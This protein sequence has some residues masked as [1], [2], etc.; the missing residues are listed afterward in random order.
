M[1][2]TRVSPRP[3][4]RSTQV[5]P[6]SAPLLLTLLAASLQKPWYLVAGNRD[7]YSGNVT[8]EVAYSGQSP[9]GRWQME[10]NYQKKYYTALGQPFLHMVYLD[11]WDMTSESKGNFNSP[12][13]DSAKGAAAIQWM[14]QAFTDAPGFLW[15]IV[16]THY[17]I[18]C[19]GSHG[20]KNSDL[21]GSTLEGALYLSGVDAYFAG[22]D[23]SLQHIPRPS[24]S[25]P[26]PSTPL[27]LSQ[28]TPTR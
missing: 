23:H 13:R 11:T 15:R 14:R 6:P 8:A 19:S 12:P 25:T 21:T 9:N 24:P 7:Y 4:R 20:P 10:L 18:Y 2:M 3:L 28:P 17:P 26:P 22:H 5:P 1:S 27:S 16:V